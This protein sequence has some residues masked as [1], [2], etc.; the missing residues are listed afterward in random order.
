M[1]NSER[2]NPYMAG[3]SIFVSLLSALTI[4]GLP[5]EVYLYGDA[6]VWRLLGCILGLI[7]CSLVF[8]PK[9][10]ELKLYSIFRLQLFKY[11]FSTVS[12]CILNRLKLYSDAI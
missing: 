11:S 12:I 2:M 10:Y 3:L 9:V 1:L 5:V 7:V 4:I 6:M 8:L